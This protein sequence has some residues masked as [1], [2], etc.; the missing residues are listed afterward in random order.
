LAGKSLNDLIQAAQNILGVYKRFFA[1]GPLLF[2][3][4]RCED[5]SI[6]V[7]P[8]DE[9]AKKRHNSF[10]KKPAKC[11]TLCKLSRKR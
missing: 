2:Q 10:G 11:G 3:M 1:F 4:F 6:Q 5:L 7:H 8:N 9:L